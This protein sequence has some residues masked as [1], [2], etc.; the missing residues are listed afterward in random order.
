ME[1]LLVLIVVVFSIV[2]I[3]LAVK[4]NGKKAELHKLTVHIQ[5][6]TVDQELLQMVEQDNH[7]LT[8]HIQELTV[9][10]QD[11]AHKQYRA[12]V[13][14]DSQNIRTQ[15]LELARR[16]AAAALEEWKSSSELDVHFISSSSV[17]S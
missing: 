7:K 2:L 11:L 14:S 10:M 15:Q 6:L 1:A 12:W 3:V 4:Y 17:D 9:H 16:E 8:V 13:D 5:E